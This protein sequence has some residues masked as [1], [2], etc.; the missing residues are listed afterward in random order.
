VYITGTG[1][2]AAL[3]VRFGGISAS[4]FTVLSDTLIAAVAPPQAAATQH[5]QV[6]TYGGGSNQTSADQYTYTT[7]PVPSVTAISPT[8][9]PAAGGTVVTIVGSA[10]TGA[11][12]V[13]FGGIGASSYTVNSDN[14]ITA[15][16]PPGTQGNTVDVI[17]VAYSGSSSTSAA[18]R[19]T[20]T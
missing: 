12:A 20:Y 15:T 11:I 18:D 13:N 6:T 19:F 7:G 17:V 14:S 2:T 9:G 5:I 1:F 10:F 16:S 3:S 4:S 8:S